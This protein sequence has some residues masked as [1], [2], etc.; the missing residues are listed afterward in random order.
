ML[1]HIHQ[2]LANYNRVL[3]NKIIFYKFEFKKRYIDTTNMKLNDNS[4]LNNKS[5]KI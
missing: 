1:V 5:H 3:K 4:Y 2:S